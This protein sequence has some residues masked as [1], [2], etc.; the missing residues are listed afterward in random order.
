MTKPWKDDDSRNRW[1]RGSV[2]SIFQKV[3]I[4]HELG[5]S[6][7]SFLLSLRYCLCVVYTL[8]A[9]TKKCSKKLCY[10]NTMLLRSF[11]ALM[12][13]WFIVYFMLL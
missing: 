6:Y 13:L 3:Q 8:Y 10:I 1:A 11:N 2:R 5:F 7:A 9:S 4:I 12:L